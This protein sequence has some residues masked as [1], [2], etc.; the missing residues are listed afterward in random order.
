MPSIGD[1]RISAGTGQM[2]FASKTV[3]STA[4]DVMSADRVASD[5]K[6]ALMVQDMQGAMA[7]LDAKLTG[8]LRDVSDLKTANDEL[9]ASLAALV[10]RVT[11]LEA[12]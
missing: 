7:T 9:T 6:L 2:K 8:A 1:S 11:T 5:S 3:S 12:N 10:A 4:P